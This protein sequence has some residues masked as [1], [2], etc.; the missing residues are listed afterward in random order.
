ERNGGSFVA[1]TENR[2]VEHGPSASDTI[3]TAEAERRRRVVSMYRDLAERLVEARI[4][5]RKREAEILS[6]HPVIKE[7]EAYG[8]RISSAATS[9]GYVATWEQ[10]A[11]NNLEAATLVA[12]ARNDLDALVALD[13]MLKSNDKVGDSTLG[14]VMREL[15][16]R[17]D[18]LN[19]AK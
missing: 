11:Q 13:E 12:K 17:T 1:V 5:L 8:Q 4:E 16:S 15:V 9:A 7:V 2:P 19:M 3:N 18:F 14:E 6:A 10:F